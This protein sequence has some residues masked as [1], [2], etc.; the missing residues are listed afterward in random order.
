MRY[1]AVEQHAGTLR[2]F[3]TKDNAGEST[4]IF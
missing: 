2:Q 1:H 3:G 4:G